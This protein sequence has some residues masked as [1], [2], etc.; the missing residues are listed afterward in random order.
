MKAILLST[1]LFE[2][3]K[4]HIC[5]MKLLLKLSEM[6]FTFFYGNQ[7]LWGCRITLEMTVECSLFQERLLIGVEALLINILLKVLKLTQSPD[8]N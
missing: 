5:Q 8:K 1:S 2:R 7:I 3:V 4:S 6:I